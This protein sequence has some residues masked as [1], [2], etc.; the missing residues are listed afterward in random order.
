ML[1]DFH[2]LHLYGPFSKPLS[3]VLRNNPPLYL[4]SGGGLN[5]I[6]QTGILSRAFG[7]ARSVA[8]PSRLAIANPESARGRAGK[9]I[10]SWTVTGEGR[11]QGRP[12]NGK[13]FAT[14][15]WHRVPVVRGLEL[16]VHEG[17]PLAKHIGEAQDIADAVRL[18]VNRVLMRGE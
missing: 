15:K 2:S 8:P 13:R 17:H 11:E 9:A 14:T 7:A 6:G 1:S 12:E 3:I 16:H 5:A 18:A 4:R 10:H